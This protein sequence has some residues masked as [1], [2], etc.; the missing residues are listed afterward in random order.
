MRFGAGAIPLPRRPRTKQARLQS[1]VD[2]EFHA[3]ENQLEMYKYL[4]SEKGMSEDALLETR[5]TRQARGTLRS[6]LEA[7]FRGH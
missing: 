5:L 3:Q 2:D 1:N 4:K 7:R 6:T